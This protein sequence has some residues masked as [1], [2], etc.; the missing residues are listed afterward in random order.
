MIE[1]DRQGV[2]E[3]A[4]VRDALLVGQDLERRYAVA[5]PVEAQLQGLAAAEAPDPCA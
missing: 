2:V 1:G 5:Q 4:D 3:V